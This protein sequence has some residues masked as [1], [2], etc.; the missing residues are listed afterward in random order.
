MNNPLLIEILSTTDL[1]LTGEIL[2]ISR[3]IKKEA[4]FLWEMI[5]L[6]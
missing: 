2:S 4:V 5:F 6:G 3:R 1:I